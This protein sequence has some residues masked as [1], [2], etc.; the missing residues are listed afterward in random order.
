MHPVMR[1]IVKK[2]ILQEFLDPDA[3]TDH[4]QNLTDSCDENLCESLY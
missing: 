1:R 3:D 4:T 2:T